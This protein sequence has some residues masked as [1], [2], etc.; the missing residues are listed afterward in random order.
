ML[1]RLA[2]LG[3]AAFGPALQ[4]LVV[5]TP[6]EARLLFG[7]GPL[8]DAFE[9]VD[10]VFPQEV[11]LVRLD[12]KA[13]SATVNLGALGQ[14][15]FT[16][17]A[18]GSIGNGITLRANQDGLIV[19]APDVTE[20]GYLFTDFP[21]LGSLALALAQEAQRG[22]SW[23][24][25]EADQELLPPSVLAGQEI[26]LA[27]GYDE[28]LSKDALA[29]RL[30]LAYQSLDGLA[31]SVVCP[32][33]AALDDNLPVS[34]YGDAF[35]G[36]A[37]YADP[38]DSLS[39]GKSFHGPLL[40]FCQRQVKAGIMTVGVLGLRDHA[41]TDQDLVDHLRLTDL[42]SRELLNVA[43]QDRG[44]L[45]SVF[46]VDLYQGERLVPGAAI[47]AA[48][49]AS[50]GPLGTTHMALPQVTGMD[51]AYSLSARRAAA[52]LGVVLPYIDARRVVRIGSGVTAAE[53]G[54]PL[55]LLTNVRQVQEA[56]SVFRGELSR[57]LRSTYPQ[58][59][60]LSLIQPHLEQVAEELVKEQRLVAGAQVHV[61]LEGEKV[62]VFLDLLP[63]DT[64]EW[65]SAQVVMPMGEG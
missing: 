31:V 45:L 32:L 42:G 41:T 30:Q 20:R 62:G 58:T 34:S 13:A 52:E 44:G 29:D 40:D 27:G 14:V 56:V 43:G 26:Q 57:L 47:Y 17:W 3:T 63:W 48:A 60:L 51:A 59:L 37:F 46:G 24:L 18:A 6:I 53:A 11:Y 36:S 9:A 8:V 2:L 12:G 21:T 16:A 33:E 23:V 64:T 19:T 35:Y 65:V 54:H 28:T 4:P 7:A 22:E 5:S 38:N 55:H 50:S 1:G 49:V 25:L 39:P 10:Q 15:T 61:Q